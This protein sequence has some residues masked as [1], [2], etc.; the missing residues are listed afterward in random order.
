MPTAGCPARRWSWSDPPERDTRWGTGVTLENVLEGFAALAI[1]IGVGALLAHVGLVDL[2]AQRVLNT[3]AFYAGSP[4]LLLMTLAEADVH[5][6]FSANLVA[7]AVSV[8]VPLVTYFVLGRVIWQRPGSE[9][10]VGA[11]TAS[12]VNAGNLG[13]PIAAYVLGNAAYVA[14]TLMLQLLVMQ[15]LMLSVLDASAAGRRPRVRDLAV[16]PLTNPLTLGTLGGLLL[17]VTGWQLPQFIAQPVD[18]IGGI[19]V[20]GMLIAYGIALRL[21]PGLG[22]GGSRAELGLLVCLKL[23]VQPLVAWGVGRLLGLAGVDLLAVVVC[24]SLPTAQN[25]FVIASR[26]GRADTLARDV[27]L[28]TTM[29]SPVAIL[30]QSLLLG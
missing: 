9:R 28:V 7:T 3:V 30:V 6:L 24:A 11:M 22:G 15:P 19:A 29:L 1:V 21:G 18:L 2:G 20:P 8:T 25:I 10:V 13:L 4:A 5:A 17:S 26:Y 16:T 23:L 14:P 27:I 12:Y